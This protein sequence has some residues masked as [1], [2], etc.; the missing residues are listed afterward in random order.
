MRSS[1]NR[2]RVIAIVVGVTGIG[3][4]AGYQVR[5][6][7]IRQF[8]V[9]LGNEFAAVESKRRQEEETLLPVGSIAPDIV[10]ETSSKALFSLKEVRRSNKAILINFW[11]CECGACQR[12]LPLLVA[13]QSTFR[14]RGL[15]VISVNNG[16]SLPLVQQWVLHNRVSFPV[17]MAGNKS[18]D[19]GETLRKYH[20]SAYPTSYLIDSQ[21]QVRWR[22]VGVADEDALRA[23]LARIGI[24]QRYTV[25]R[26]HRKRKT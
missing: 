14:N 24:S 10:L 8:I 21:A 19:R 1:I 22:G 26:L 20:V 3:S 13:L 4:V 5:E 9:P 23:A 18:L 16:D 6:W 11:F 12:E 7:R 2:W 17:A 15:A 25:P